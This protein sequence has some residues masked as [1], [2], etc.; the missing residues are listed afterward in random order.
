MTAKD[1]G[2]EKAAAG[3]QQNDSELNKK[4]KISMQE[5]AHYKMDGELNDSK[6]T[7]NTSAVAAAQNQI[8]KID[9]FFLTLSS[10]F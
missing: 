6:W 9:F 2:Y 10:Q 3:R 7:H 4:K 1:R 5:R 8:L